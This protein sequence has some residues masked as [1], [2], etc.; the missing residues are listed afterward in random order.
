MKKRSD[1]AQSATARLARSL[2]IE[3]EYTNASGKRIVVSPSAIRGILAAMGHSVCDDVEA[4]ELLK[5]L[6]EISTL[7]ELPPVL[8]VRQ[9]QQP[10]KILINS[11]PGGLSKRWKV[12]REDQKIAEEGFLDELGQL[13]SEE[14]V[15]KGTAGQKRLE[16]SVILPCGYHRLELDN[17]SSMPLIVVP[18]KCWLGT[19]EG[20]KKTWGLAIQ[21]YLLRSAR[22]WGMGDFSDLCTLVAF[23][24][25]EGASL[26]GLNPLHALFVDDPEH[27]SPYAPASR[28]YLN[29][30]NIDPTSIPE[31]AVSEK[32]KSL[33][34]SSQFA[35]RVDSARAS[36]MVNYQNVAD[37][38]LRM[39]KLIYSDFRRF[40]S[41]DRWDALKAFIRDR[42]T[43]LSGF[44]T[45][46]A[47]RRELTL[48]GLDPNDWEQW[49]KELRQPHS[50]SIEG[51]YDDHRDEVD[52][53]IWS[54]W[55]ADNQLHEAASRAESNKMA[56]GLYRDL[57]VGSSAAGAERW[58]NPD[59]VVAKA[60]A[61]APP[62]I[63]NPAGQDWGLPP[64]NPVRLREEGY[65]SFVELVRANMRHAGA[66][67]IDHVVGLRHLYWIAEGMHPSQGAYVTYP[68]DDLAGILALESW[69]NRCLVVGEDLGTLPAGFRDQL[70]K[71]GILSSR[72]LYFEQDDKGK[73]LPPQDCPALSLAS[74]GTHD[75]PTLDGWWSEN[76]IDIRERNDLYPE[77]R[78]ARKQ[79]RQRLKEKRQLLVVLRQ[80]GLDPGDGTDSTRLAVATHKFLARSGAGIVMAALD[81]LIGETTQVNVPTTT[82]E[83]PNWR[84]RVAVLLE[85][86]ETNQRAMRIVEALRCERPVS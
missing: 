40:A 81:D 4:T 55:I 24:S 71:R 31:F 33:F 73:F 62:D 49:P 52:F 74:I 3:L 6:E 20:D 63:L 9:E 54:Q 79:R 29:I 57:A 66:L 53:L 32:A 65:A 16:L 70:A 30:L 67:R 84:R 7:R 42:G 12:F 1:F 41:Q 13:R 35:V 80:A 21:L 14:H 36:K 51:F 64:F 28:L 2:S 45:F 15:T 5:R 76:D 25:R 56:I 68:F 10:I 11:K 39:L 44:C 38:K 46:Q 26:V 17:G 48:R 59:V 8:V 58:S 77:I 82:D 75:L 86:I 47:I 43:S 83:Y 23:A 72:V 19:I 85:E 78:E 18:S 37:L 22:N 27:A 34:A 60:H 50:P 61:G 69:R